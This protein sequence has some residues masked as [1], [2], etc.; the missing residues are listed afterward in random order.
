[1]QII[2][3]SSALRSRHSVHYCF[4]ACFTM[5]LSLSTNE[6]SRA[7]WCSHARCLLKGHKLVCTD[8]KMSS[9]AMRME[10]SGISAGSAVKPS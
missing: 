4:R 10:A 7:Q 2:K 1:M 5:A 9:V 6:I 3:I 8:D